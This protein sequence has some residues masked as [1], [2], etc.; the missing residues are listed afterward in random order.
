MLVY[1]S[2]PITEL[3]EKL[4]FQSI[5]GFSRWFKNLEGMSPQNYR[6]RARK[7]GEQ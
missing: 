6:D 7:T 1:T 2:I 3:S 5:H 4:G